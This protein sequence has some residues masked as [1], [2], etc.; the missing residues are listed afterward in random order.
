M[1]RDG[2]GRIYIT[3]GRLAKQE[4]MHWNVHRFHLQ[5]GKIQV[6]RYYSQHCTRCNHA[7]FILESSLFLHGGTKD[8]VHVSDEMV[9]VSLNHLWSNTCQATVMTNP[10]KQ[11]APPKLMNHAMFFSEELQSLQLIGGQ[12]EIEEAK[13]TAGN[14][15]IFSFDPFKM[16]WKVIKLI[17]C[18]TPLQGKM[19]C[20]IN[21]ENSSSN[22][23]SC[24]DNLSKLYR[25]VFVQGDTPSPEFGLQNYMKQMRQSVCYSDVVFE[26]SHSKQ[27]YSAV[28]CH[29]HKVIVASRCEFLNALIQKAAK[30]SKEQPMRVVLPKSCVVHLFSH[31]LD[32]LYCGEINLH[33]KE[34]FEFLN[35]VE[36][37]SPTQHYPMLLKIAS[38]GGADVNSL[39]T[40]CDEMHNDFSKALDNAS[41]FP[42]FQ[43]KLSNGQIFFA[44]KVFLARSPVFKAMFEMNHGW[45]ESQHQ[46]ISMDQFDMYHC[47]ELILLYCYSDRLLIHE[48]SVL[49]LLFTSFFLGLDAVGSLCQQLVGNYFMDE[50]NVMQLYDCASKYEMKG[51]MEC[52]FKFCDNRNIELLLRNGHWE[53]NS[54]VIQQFTTAIYNYRGQKK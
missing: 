25:C 30:Q 15:T 31:Y 12:S 10:S 20:S 27:R 32:Y 52:C 8:G 18:T 43:L 36:Q 19:D 29:A 3:G 22:V 1:C 48:N 16:E 17:K 47:M 39:S 9:Q 50:K 41:L 33:G 28:S 49:Q 5:A 45:L 51:L 13:S 44:H 7:S 11:V 26:F 37:I 4:S 53:C 34:V 35:M 14:G 38:I 2:W 54:E 6:Y 21:F 46:L 24:N 42:D 40:I 23:I